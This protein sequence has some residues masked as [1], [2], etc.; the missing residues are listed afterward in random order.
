M[1][2]SDFLKVLKKEKNIKNTKDLYEK[3]G[4]AHILK[5]K[6]RTFQQIEKGDYVPSEDL[7]AIIFNQLRPSDKKTFI[8]SYFRSLYRNNTNGNNLIGYLEKHLSNELESERNSLWDGG[9]FSLYS[10][11]QLS[12]LTQNTDALI[13]HRKL[14]YLEKLPTDKINLSKEKLIQ[15]QKIG[16]I[17]ISKKSVNIADK[18]YKLPVF[19]NNSPRSVS[20]ASDYILKQLELFIAKEGDQNQ[21]LGYAGQLVSINVASKVLEQMVLLK[22]W[23]HSLAS[24][25]T[26]M[27]KNIPLLYVGFLKILNWKEFE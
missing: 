11:D 15:L 7:I 3:L 10:D 23:I 19:G 17:N 12:Y 2:I 1:N 21:H 27:E 8:I 4:G 9:N 18:R 26:S 13:F 6:L 24:T 22:S 14:L 5:V 25:D 16:L 20:R